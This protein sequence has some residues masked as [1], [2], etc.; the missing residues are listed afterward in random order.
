MKRTTR[1]MAYTAIAIIGGNIL[2]FFKFKPDLI[3]IDPQKPTESPEWKVPPEWTPRIIP[4]TEY[5]KYLTQADVLF[6]N[7]QYDHASKLYA[8]YISAMRYGNEANIDTKQA[9]NRRLACELI[10]LLS[11]DIQSTVSQK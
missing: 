5:R 7:R 4:E 3:S 2:L 1:V 9:D 11:S 10:L 8:E 6:D